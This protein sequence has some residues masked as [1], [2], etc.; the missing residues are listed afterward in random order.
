MPTFT[1]EE[2]KILFLAFLRAPSLSELKRKA[3][4]LKSAS[5]PNITSHAAIPPPVLRDDEEDTRHI[6]RDVVHDED[7]VLKRARK[8]MKVEA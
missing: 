7:A 2:H 4:A 6:R 5:E 3:A 1:R 8:R